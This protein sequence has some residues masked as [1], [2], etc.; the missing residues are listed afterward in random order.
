MSALNPW[1][2]GLITLLLLLVLTGC[3]PQPGWSAQNQA[4]L[5][6][7]HLLDPTSVCTVDQPA[8]TS[9]GFFMLLGAGLLTGLSHCLGMCGPLVGAFALRRRAERKELSTPLVLFQMGRLMTYAS[10]GLLLGGLG[11]LVASTIRYWQ[12]SF[13]IVLGLLMALL[14]L[15]LFG[16]FPLQKW[17]TSIT[18]A[19]LVSG[20][21]KRLLASDHPAAPIGLG[22]ANGL[23]PCGPV[24]AMGLLATL[25]G[26][27][28]NG[29]AI[30]LIFGLGTLP[31][32]LGLGF[33]TAT[34]SLGLRSHLY[35][36]AALLVI[37]VGLQLTL[38]GLALNGQL[39]HAAIGSLM[40]W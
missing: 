2:A 15:S 40:L 1:Q 6:T 21:V 32:M 7:H 35:R 13:S 33:F 5:A 28:L 25:S 34:L 3:N 18:W 26:S 20:W 27:A 30:M 16:L 11:S 9:T 8:T 4:T 12:G 10:L 38:R 29:G 14:G 31:A 36:V 24:Y 23:L 19:R 17:L 22:L 39:S 37:I